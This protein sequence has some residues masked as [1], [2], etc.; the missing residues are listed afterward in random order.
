MALVQVAGALVL[1]G[2]LGDAELDEGGQGACRQIAARAR[3]QVARPTP[4]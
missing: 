4:R 2:E 3:S 1:L